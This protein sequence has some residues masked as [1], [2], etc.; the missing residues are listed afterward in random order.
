MTNEEESG[1]EL[2]VKFYKKYVEPFVAIFVLVLLCM[3]AKGLYDYKN[4]QQE[5]NQS[6]GWQDED[7]RCYCRKS[8]ISEIERQVINE[9][10]AIN[11]D[12]VNGSYLRHLLPFE[13]ESE[14]ER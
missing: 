1:Y 10:G 13:N 3:V 7:Y 12:N 4:L 5:I 8:E 9:R 14:I 2:L 11:F 6:C